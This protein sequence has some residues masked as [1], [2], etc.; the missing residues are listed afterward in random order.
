MRLIDALKRHFPIAYSDPP[1]LRDGLEV[2]DYVGIFTGPVNALLYA[3]LFCPPLEEVGGMVLH[4]YRYR[5]PDD[6]DAI[7]RYR[8]E[9]G[10]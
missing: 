6:D 3:R 9:A 8:E 10:G 7:R 5:A 1:R 4:R 2:E